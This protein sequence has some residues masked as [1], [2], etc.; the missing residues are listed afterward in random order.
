M[1]R[2]RQDLYYDY[3]E[4][5]VAPTAWNPRKKRRPLGLL[6]WAA[7]VAVVGWGAWALFAFGVV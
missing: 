4:D 6:P 5:I 3:L 7:V 2:T 1:T